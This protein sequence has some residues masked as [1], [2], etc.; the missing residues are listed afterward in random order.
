MERVELKLK[1]GDRAYAIIKAS[2]VMV[3]NSPDSS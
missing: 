3:G 1:P 2:D